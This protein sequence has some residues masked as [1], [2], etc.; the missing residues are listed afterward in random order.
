MFLNSNRILCLGHRIYIL[1][2]NR[3][4]TSWTPAD[5]AD[6]TSAESLESRA[7]CVWH[8]DSAFKTASL[9]QDMRSP[10]ERLPIFVFANW[11]GFSGGRRDMFREILK[12][13]SFI[14]EE[15]VDISVPVFVYVPESAEL[16]GGAWVVLDSKYGVPFLWTAVLLS[17]PVTF[18]FFV[19]LCDMFFG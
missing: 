8:P 6:V 7:P 15:L 1:F 12:F 10:G 3:L 17:F 5:P 9:L 4:T 16:R 14:V 11:R 13:G 2:S 18:F 19:T